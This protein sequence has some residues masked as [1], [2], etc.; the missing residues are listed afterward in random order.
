MKR[1]ALI[2]E[3]SSK[4]FKSNVLE[5]MKLFKNN[6]RDIYLIQDDNISN[7]EYIVINS[8]VDSSEGTINSK[9]CLA[10]MDNLFDKDISVCGKLITY[11]FGSKN[12]ITIS[13]VE[14]DN[15]GF[16]YCIQR[17]IDIDSFHRIEP[18]EIPI[19]LKFEDEEELYSYMAAITILLI[20]NVGDEKF[21][22]N[23]SEKLIINK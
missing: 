7:T 9:Y 20:E 23:L 14:D 17:Y 8:H 10:N 11:G 13:S 21:F 15:E 16:V 18:Q 4:K 2:E 6:S 5:F 22:E 19:Q 3:S 12:T 1:I